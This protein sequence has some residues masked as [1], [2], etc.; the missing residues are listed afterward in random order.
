[1]AA[2]TSYTESAALMNDPAFKGRVKVACLTYADYI[3]G[4]AANV[5]AHTSRMRWAGMTMQNPDM[6]AANVTPTA[7]MDPAVQAA[8]GEIDDAGL[9]GAVENAVNKML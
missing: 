1:M 3:S 6:A 2:L 7:V 4:E 5:P 9:Q 8:G